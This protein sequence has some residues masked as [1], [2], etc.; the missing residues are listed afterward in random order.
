M[1]TKLSQGRGSDDYSETRS[2]H[3]ISDIDWTQARELFLAVIELSATATLMV[4]EEEAV[5]GACNEAFTQLSGYTDDY[6]Q[7]YSLDQLLK[8]GKGLQREGQSADGSVDFYTLHTSSQHSLLVTCRA[9]TQI[10]RGRKLCFLSIAEAAP[11]G[12][13][14]RQWTHADLLLSR[15]Q[16]RPYIWTVDDQGSL[17][18]ANDKARQLF[19][20]AR[21]DI[22]NAVPFDQIVAGINSEERKKLQQHFQEVLSRGHKCSFRFDGLFATGFHSFKVTLYPLRDQDAN[23]RGVSFVAIEQGDSNVQ[24]TLSGILEDFKQ[25]LFGVFD[26][27]QLEV[28]MDKTLGKMSFSSHCLVRFSEEQ[29]ELVGPVRDPQKEELPSLVVI[30]QL[31]QEVHDK[32]EFLNTLHDELSGRSA[33]VVPVVAGGKIE[34]GI[35][36]RSHIGARTSIYQETLEKT[37]Y[38]FLIKYQSLVSNR[39]LEDINRS[40]RAIINSTPN[41]F[42]LFDADI[43]MVACNRT[44][45]KSFQNMLGL[46][47][48]KGISFSEFIPEKHSISFVHYCREA[49]QGNVNM[50]DRQFKHPESGVDWYR[51]TFAPARDEDDNIFGVTVIMANIT[52]ERSAEQQMLFK[53]RELLKANK[54]LDKF[55]YSVSHDLRAPIANTI[56]LITIMKAEGVEG[57]MLRYANMIESTMR[58]MDAFIHQILDY[59]RNN[60]LEL[61]L[62]TINCRELIEEMLEDF[63]YYNASAQDIDFRL[64]VPEDA[65]LFSDRQRLK[66]ILNNLISNAIK[67]H[68]E[69]REGKYIEVAITADEKNTYLS[70]KDNGQGI[71]AEHIPHLFEMFYTANLRAE[72]SGIGLYILKDAT[73]QLKGKI[74][75]DSYFGEGSE[76]LITLPKLQ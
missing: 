11:L 64:K 20:V 51:I 41:A 32:R 56:G 7:G 55:V 8:A 14:Q 39:K 44:A 53:N 18:K 5:V 54:E 69:G 33:L 38:L 6:L 10:F 22:Q 13:V 24:D 49:L 21:E 3:P 45:R 73:E 52:S 19:A 37:V 17:Q 68:D 67:Y 15:Q 29:Q 50:V 59:S 27:Q 65:P 74:E 72:G 26:L 75:V 66:I 28:L 9:K 70:V 36:C 40:F 60:R 71:K 25:D 12:R 31:C 43:R 48:Q 63:G 4:D 46:Q 47:L 2:Q 30:R 23:L 34:Y 1:L 58:R 16:A 35:Y 57:E 61:K 62:E 76:F 42:M